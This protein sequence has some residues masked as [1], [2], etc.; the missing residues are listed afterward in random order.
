VSPDGSNLIEIA[1]EPQGAKGLIAVAW[2]PDGSP[3]AYIGTEPG[4]IQELWPLGIYLMEPDG[5]KPRKLRDVGECFCGGG[6]AGPGITWSPDG[7]Q[8][9]FTTAGLAGRS[10]LAGGLYVMD[11]DGGEPRRLT[12]DAAA[13]PALAAN[14][15]SKRLRG[16]KTQQIPRHQ[17]N[18]GDWAADGHET[19][20]SAY[21]RR[22]PPVA[23]DGSSSSG[24]G[25]QQTIQWACG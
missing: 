8:I 16:A 3:I 1:T 19:R 10:N 23:R 15:E 13:N 7:T 21:R 4:T 25:L 11:A 24:L 5:T 9:A 17:T 14:S 22:N 20:L 2:S 18:L 6:W 12:G